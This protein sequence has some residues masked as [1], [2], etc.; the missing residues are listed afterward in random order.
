MNGIIYLISGIQGQGIYVGQTLDPNERW[1]HHEYEL[2]TGKHHNIYLQRSWVKHGSDAY[3]FVVQEEVP[4]ADLTN[5]EQFWLDEFPRMGVTLY[6]IN[7]V[8]AKPPSWLGRKRGPLSEERKQ[9]LREARLRQP[10][11]RT[12][13][14]HSQEAKKKM[15][16]A[17]LRR[18]R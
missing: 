18:V 4:E 16:L 5:R 10:C 17:A 1:Y 8:A 6:N 7:R 2:N 3:A 14:K 9:A 15:S 13:K 11:P 12:G